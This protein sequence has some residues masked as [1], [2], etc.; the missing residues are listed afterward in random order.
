MYSL[1]SITSLDMLTAQF[2]YLKSKFIDI[3]TKH[4]CKMELN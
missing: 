2:E 4:L 3:N 1:F